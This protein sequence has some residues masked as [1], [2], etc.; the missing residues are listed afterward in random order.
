VTLKLRYAD[1]DTRTRAR[2]LTQPTND[3]QRLFATV[4]GLLKGAWTRALPIRLV[5]VALPNLSGPSRQ[6][7]L[8]AGESPPRPVGPAIDAVR[9]RFGYDAIRLGATGSTR[10]L[11]QRPATP[12]SPVKKGGE[13][14]PG[15][16]DF[17]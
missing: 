7:A 6:L 15:D 4:R 14:P 8:F 16:A 3:E 10:W 12:D 2:T 13:S 17:E 9:A 5:G 11:E 1:F